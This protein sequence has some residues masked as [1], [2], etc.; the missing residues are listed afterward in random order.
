MKPSNTLSLVGRILITLSI[1]LACAFL[2]RAQ[3]GKKSPPPPPPHNSAPAKPAAPKP[4]A[5]P[6]PQ[7]HPTPEPPQQHPVQQQPRSQPAVQQRPEPPAQQPQQ[8][9]V[10]Q[11][12]RSAP[13]RTPLASPGTKTSTSPAEDP[14][15]TFTPWTSP[16]PAGRGAKPL[17]VNSAT[18]TTPTTPSAPTKKPSNA[19]ASTPVVPGTA[20][21]ASGGRTVSTPAGNRLDFGKG[22]RLNSV[23]TNKGTEAHFDHRG[24]VST[25]KTAA[26]M[27]IVHNPAGGRHIVTEHRDARGHVESRVVG[28]GPNRGFAE[29]AVQR[30]GHEYMHRTYVHEGR[31]YT[32]VSRGYYYHGSIYYH[33]VP[34][35]YFAP[36]Y[37]EWGYGPW[38]QPIAYTG[39]GWD[40]SPWYGW[41]G[42]YFAPYP[43]YPSAAFWLTDFVIA[44][45]LKAAYEAQA[46]ANAAAANAEAA[47]ADANAAAANA[48]GAAANA[49]AAAANASAAAT[50]QGS[51]VGAA[52]LTPE[53]KEMIAEEVKAQL[54]AEQAAAQNARA[55]GP[56]VPQQSIADS[57]R[58]PAAL[59]PNRRVFIVSSDL[60]VSVNGQPCLLLPG[61]VL[62]RTEIVPDRDNTVAV[63]VLKSQKFDCAAGTI[64]RIQVADLQEMHNHF[65]EQM[66][67]GLK[68][69]ADNQGKNGLP[70]APAAASPHENPE[71]TAAPDDAAAIA[72]QLN[73]QRQEAE[74]AETEVQQAA[75]ASGPAGGVARP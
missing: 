36:A 42:Y 16:T 22:G 12:Q 18:K 21:H 26:G 57:Y 40:D 49:N 17:A 35:Y 52:A 41:S 3:G 51:Q 70:S 63:Y 30:G 32:T 8:H 71:G 37:Y 10:R 13:G 59:D 25:I 27:T 55:T 4:A 1:L 43:V 15:T 38:G 74:Q 65:R 44:E 6:A 24:Q 31:T 62:N 54:A 58:V 14:S 56:S 45:N 34:A 28:T 60:E 39:W 29:H 47:A 33:Y 73:Q 2:S 9:Q 50:Q 61:D 11:P 68:T 53:V 23:V 69:L 48:D 19:A 72:A 7:Q 20:G 5:T 67:A 75:S 66:D 46:A 64:P